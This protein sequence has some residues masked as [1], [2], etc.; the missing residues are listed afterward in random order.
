MIAEAGFTC[1]T[2]R[3]KK[4]RE[5]RKVKASCTYICHTERRKRKREV[6]MVL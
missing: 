3:K 5:V 2:E 6:K 4:K 1:Y